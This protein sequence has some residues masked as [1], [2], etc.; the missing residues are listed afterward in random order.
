MTMEEVVFDPKGNLT[1]RGPLSYRIP[2]CTDIPGKLNVHL[3]KDSPNPRAAV[4]SSKV[5]YGSTLRKV[6]LTLLYC[7]KASR[8][9]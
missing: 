8:H 5:S 1:T 6:L 2:R 7:L 9:M 4:Y 3:L